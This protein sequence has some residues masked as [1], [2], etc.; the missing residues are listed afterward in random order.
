[1]VDTKPT[2]KVPMKVIKSKEKNYDTR[3]S[4]HF[5]SDDLPDLKHWEVGQEYQLLV[6]VKQT[7]THLVDY[8]KMK[9]K[10]R[11][12]FTVIGV[13]AYSEKIK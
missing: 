11:G 5:D 12:D 2:R 3:P 4:L 1:M 8:G 9:G 7:G 10:I 13:K 6:K